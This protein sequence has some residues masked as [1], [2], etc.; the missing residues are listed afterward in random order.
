MSM[1]TMESTPSHEGWPLLAPATLGE[2]R[3]V[4]QILRVAHGEQETTL[5]CVV[6]VSAEQLSIVGVTALGLRAFTVKFDGES[7]T[8]EALPGVPQ[9]MSPER[10]LNDAQL[11]Y[12]PLAELKKAMANSPWDISEPAPGTRRLRH[13][14]KLIA[15]VHYA[16]RADS[17]WHDRVWLVNLEFGYTLAIDSKAPAS[18]A[19]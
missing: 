10:L 11:A 8:A 14:G 19:Q 6:S 4:N 3:T 2:T 7:I 1:R 18:G 16:Q 9:S 15:E 13:G 12:W 17:P 5:N